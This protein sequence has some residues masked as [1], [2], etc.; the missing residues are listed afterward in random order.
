MLKNLNI[1]H[2]KKVERA[3]RQTGELSSGYD[4]QLGGVGKL[5][6]VV[7]VPTTCPHGTNKSSVLIFAF[8]NDELLNINVFSLQ[9]TA[10]ANTT[11]VGSHAYVCQTP[12][13]EDR[14][15]AQTGNLTARTYCS[16][17][18]SHY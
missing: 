6:G 15:F 3:T 7:F 17:H 5:Y 8:T 16:Y 11:R 14:V 1:F 10:R 13:V 12:E 2:R 9:F 4:V 18:V